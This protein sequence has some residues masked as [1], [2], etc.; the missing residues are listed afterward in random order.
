MPEEQGAGWAVVLVRG[1]RVERSAK[2]RRMEEG[3][4]AIGEL[5]LA[6]GNPIEVGQLTV[7]VPIGPGADESQQ[8]RCRNGE[9]YSAIGLIAHEACAG[10]G[11]PCQAEQRR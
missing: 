5:C 11:E 7:Y 10:G 9:L 1:P 3:D 4:L 2:R 8:A 6:C